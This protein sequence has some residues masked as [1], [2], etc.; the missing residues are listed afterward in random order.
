MLKCKKLC[1]IFTVL[2]IIGFAG[3]AYAAFELTASTDVKVMTAATCNQA[4]SYT[5]S[6][7]D[8]LKIREG[9]VI[10]FSLTNNVTVCDSLDY[11]LVLCDD[12]S[13]MLTND[14][15]YPVYSNDNYGIQGTAG[16]DYLILTGGDTAFMLGN[17]SNYVFGLHIQATAGTGTI[18]AT[19]SRCDIVNGYMGRTDATDTLATSNYMVME[20]DGSDGNS[21]DSKLYISLFDEK[22][23]SATLAVNNAEG[24]SFFRQ[25]GTVSTATTSYNRLYVSNIAAEDNALCIDTVTGA[26]TFVNGE[27]VE[28]TPSSNPTS[29][30]YR[31]NFTGTYRIAKVSGSTSM[32]ISAVGKG[33]CPDISLYTQT[34]QSGNA[35]SAATTFQPGVF[36]T[37]ACGSGIDTRWSGASTNI[38]Q[39]TDKGRGVIITNSTNFSTNEKYAISLTLVKH[40]S[41]SS[42]YAATSNVW[43]K[44]GD[45]SAAAHYTTSSNAAN[46]ACSTGTASAIVPASDTTWAG[47]TTSSFTVIPP[48]GTTSYV[49][50]HTIATG[51]AGNDWIDVGSTYTSKN[52]LMV[53]LPNIYID[54]NNLQVGDVIGVTVAISKYPCGVLKSETVCLGTITATQCPTYG[55]ACTLTYSYLVS[56]SNEGFWSGLA[57]TNLSTLAGTARMVFTDASGNSATVSKSMAANAIEAM[58]FDETYA[59]ANLTGI[60]TSKNMKLQITTDFSAEGQCLIMSKE[61]GGGIYGYPSRNTCMTAAP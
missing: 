40:T 8:G 56:P 18:S 16:S 30:T 48:D 43:W 51:S 60:D 32:T 54:Y 11:F 57:L 33:A 52:S 34:D 22:Y 39:E 37:A 28:A 4:G 1:Y 2:F 25:K 49:G 17:N 38:C 19:A 9:D 14:V 29:E 61:V 58:L 23:N 20:Y 59:A 27:Y 35:V 7:A 3:S 50:Y 44:T 13:A 31:L 6:A 55:S 26:P 46:T 47:L 45:V 42:T 15:S 21:A 36:S 24:L 5:M 53:D 12:D 41:S 10:L